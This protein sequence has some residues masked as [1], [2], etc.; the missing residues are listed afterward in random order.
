MTLLQKTALMNNPVSP[1]SNVCTKPGDNNHSPVH[2]LPWLLKVT[3]QSTPTMWND[4]YCVV[5]QAL[6]IIPAS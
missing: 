5:L 4:G 1:S 3:P 6:S 2:E